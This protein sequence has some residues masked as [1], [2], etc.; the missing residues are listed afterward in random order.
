MPTKRRTGVA[1]NALI[2]AGNLK[3]VSTLGPNA[4][5]EGSGAYVVLTAGDHGSLLVPTASPAATAEMRTQF[6]KFA[7]SA[8]QPGGPFLVITN[9]AVVEK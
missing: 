3:K 9:P 8:A 7:A 4:V 6:I 1:T 5:G 2:T